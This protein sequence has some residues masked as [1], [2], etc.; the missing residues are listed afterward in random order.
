MTEEKLQSL[1]DQ[2][3]KVLIKIQQG[4]LSPDTLINNKAPITKYVNDNMKY[5]VKGKRGHLGKCALL[6]I[7]NLRIIVHDQPVMLIDAAPYKAAGLIPDDAEVI[8]AKSHTTFR[9]GFQKISKS[10]FV[11]NT[12]GP[13]PIDL[14]N[15]DYVNRPHPLHPFE[16]IND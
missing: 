6:G 11:S 5:S 15:L 2:I 14:T 9:S 4:E 13:T 12:P 8:Q 3:D 7:E 10:F 1:F 16:I